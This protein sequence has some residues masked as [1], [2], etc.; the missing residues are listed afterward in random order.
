MKDSGVAHGDCLREG[1]N[2]TGHPGV[3][4]H[5]RPS[6]TLGLEFRTLLLDVG[7]RASDHSQ[8]LRLRSGRRTWEGNQG[9][10]MGLGVLLNTPLLSRGLL[11]RSKGRHGVVCL[12]IY[13]FLFVCFSFETTEFS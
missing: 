4:Q 1:D 6:N 3:L 11:G 7:V 12:V 2:V 8:S 13:R 5:R 9:S 10:K